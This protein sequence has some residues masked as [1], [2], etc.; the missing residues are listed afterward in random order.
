MHEL[1]KTFDKSIASQVAKLP[2]WLTPL[3]MLCTFLGLPVVI[4]TMSFMLAGYYYW[5]DRKNLAAAFS[6][7]VVALGANGILKLI[8]HR[9]RPDTL[10]V[11]SMAIK[12]YSFPSGHAFGSMVFYGLIAYLAYQQFSQPFNSLVPVVLGLLI[13]TIGISRIFLGAHFPSDVVSGWLLG[14]LALVA[15][16]KAC[17]L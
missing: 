15:I 4:V 14:A 7:A 11:Q 16:I 6:L 5:Q 2:T 12:S 8:L 13:I 1:L 9:S 10:Y 3:M 17:K